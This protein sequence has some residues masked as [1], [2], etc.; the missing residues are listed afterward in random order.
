VTT[1]SRKYAVLSWLIIYFSKKSSANINKIP[2]K[3]VIRLQT[4]LFLNLIIKLD[5]NSKI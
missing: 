5:G 2:A 3:A 4:K 1:S